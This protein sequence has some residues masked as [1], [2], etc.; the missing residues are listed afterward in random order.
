ML[1][2]ESFQSF[3]ESLTIPS[4]ADVIL[5]KFKEMVAGSKLYFPKEPTRIATKPNLSTIDMGSYD[6]VIKRSPYGDGVRVEEIDGKPTLVISNSRLNMLLQ[7]LSTWAFSYYDYPKERASTRKATLAY[8]KE[9]L[10][11]DYANIRAAIVEVWDMDGERLRNHVSN[12]QKVLFDKLYNN[13]YPLSENERRFKAFTA[14]DGN[15]YYIHKSFKTTEH[16]F[17]VYDADQKQVALAFFHVTPTHFSGYTHM[18]SIEIDPA[19]RRLGIATA[20]TDFAE[21]YFQLPYKPSNALSP[22]MELFVKNRFK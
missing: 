6:V 21:H 19:Y 5:N 1:H 20:I 9:L 16:Q 2:I 8:I 15:T 14:K 13:A 10:A 18:E 3:S 11:Y 22:A 12:P 4:E 7:N 17:T